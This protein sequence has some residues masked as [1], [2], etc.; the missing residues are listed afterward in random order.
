MGQSVATAVREYRKIDCDNLIPSV[1]FGR[2]LLDAKNVFL[3][4]AP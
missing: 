1:L 2:V 3:N 4:L